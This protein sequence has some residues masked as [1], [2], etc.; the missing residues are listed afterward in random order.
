MNIPE[1]IEK[2]ITSYHDNFNNFKD[3]YHKIIEI[4]KEKKS[5]QSIIKCE[6][7]LRKF[8]SQAIGSVSFYNQ[9]NEKREFY[10][11]IQFNKIIRFLEHVENKE[12]IYR[13]LYINCTE[14]YIKKANQIP[15]NDLLLEKNSIVSCYEILS[16]LVNEVKGDE[17]KFNKVF[18]K[19]EDS[20]LF[21]TLPEQINQQ[22]L[23]EI[24]I[25]LDN[26]IQGLKILFESLEE[27]N[28]ALREIE[29][30][31]GEI[32]SNMYDVNYHLWDIS[33]NVSSLNS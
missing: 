28:R 12:K 5:L 30:N 13:D 22:Y 21:M 26:V 18:I 19:L 33:W 9:L 7:A 14:N 2:T 23:R 15:I 17:V 31:T 4:E 27:T 20:G 29:G 24:S 6:L 3:C 32:S 10:V 25:K 1:N 8:P 16:V 11:D